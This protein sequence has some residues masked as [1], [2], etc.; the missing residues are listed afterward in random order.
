ML[1]F[2]LF[3]S[4]WA[5]PSVKCIVGTVVRNSSWP[6]GFH[7]GLE[8]NHLIPPNK[9]PRIPR[10]ISLLGRLI[11]GRICIASLSS[12]GSDHGFH[13]NYFERKMNRL[14]SDFRLLQLVWIS[15][16]VILYGCRSLFCSLQRVPST[17]ISQRLNSLVL[18]GGASATFNSRSCS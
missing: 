17:R 16:C 2:Y 9:T 15:I 3:L 8:R 4:L 7:Q 14:R 18:K 11:S 6:L 1:T 12:L 13:S 10:E 5:L